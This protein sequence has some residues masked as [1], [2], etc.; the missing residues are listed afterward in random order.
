M[1]EDKIEGTAKKVEGSV[2]SGFGNV[3]GD[4]TQEFK[5]KAKKAM[6]SVQSAFGK[7]EDCVQD[8]FES[9]QARINDKPVQSTLIALG[10]GFVLGRLFTL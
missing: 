10:V 3:I 5:G 2:Q 8:S 6:G 4:H 1:N 9:V 7:A